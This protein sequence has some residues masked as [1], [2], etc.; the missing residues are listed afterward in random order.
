MPAPSHVIAFAV[1]D[2]SCCV[3]AVAARL[4]ASLGLAVG[5]APLGAA[6]GDTELV[7]PHAEHRGADT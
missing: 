1:H 2:D 4:Y 5:E 3:I 6:W 7:W